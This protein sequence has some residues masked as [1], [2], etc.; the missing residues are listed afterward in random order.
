MEEGG[1]VAEVAAVVAEAEVV[2]LAQRRAVESAREIWVGGLGSE[3]YH[4]I[5]NS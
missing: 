5:L 3:F 2:A 4:S 1:E